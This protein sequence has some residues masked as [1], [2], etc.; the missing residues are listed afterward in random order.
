ME[1]I[2]E[3]IE[4]DVQRKVD[5]IMEEKK[6]KAEQVKKEIER[7]K[8]RRLEEIQRE[9]EREIKTLKNRIISQ[10]EL[11]ARKMRLNVREN[12]IEKVFERSKERLEEMDISEY[13]GYIKGSIEK[14]KEILE[15]EI[16][17]HCNKENEN[18]IKEIAKNIDPS[19][20]VIGDL[21]SIGGIKA[22]SEKGATIDM[23]F[24]ANLERKKKQLRKEI[25][26]ILFSEE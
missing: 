20:K 23:T 18:R 24:E 9:K 21:R 16:E 12:M 10:A 11:E 22:V 13:H 5:S 1:K 3:R 26:E 19:L 8:E 25:S 4:N 2:V 7:E 17:I 6:E 14:S 15:G